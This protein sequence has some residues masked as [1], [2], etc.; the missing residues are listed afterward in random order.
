MSEALWQRFLW[1]LLVLVSWT[2]VV[3]S[4]RSTETWL[5]SKIRARNAAILRNLGASFLQPTVALCALSKNYFLISQ[6]GDLRL[7]CIQ[8]TSF[9]VAIATSGCLS[10]FFLFRRSQD[11]YRIFVMLINKYSL[12]A[13][14]NARDGISESSGFQNF[15]GGAFS[16]TPIRVCAF[17]VRLLVNRSPFSLV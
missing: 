2:K 4:V 14:R 10:R 11:P 1:V 8:I 6:N 17:G 7:L 5:F 12:K 15:P 9:T 13:T 3:T 16:R